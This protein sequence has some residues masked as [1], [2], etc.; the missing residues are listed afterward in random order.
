[1]KHFVLIALLTLTACATV[2]AEHEQAINVTTKP[3]GASC[4][5]TNGQGMWEI[6]KTPGTVRVDRS[7][8]PLNVTCSKKGAGS[9]TQTIEANTRGRAYGNIAL[10]GI[11][12]I[13]DAATGAGYTYAAENVSLELTR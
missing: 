6:T 10:L 9:A 12:A 11:P 5:L 1:M 2:T 8:S 4:A 3:A 13:V 7:F